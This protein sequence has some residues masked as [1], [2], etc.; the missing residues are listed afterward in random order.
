MDQFRPQV[1][2]G[3]HVLCWVLLKQLTSITEL[4]PEGP[5]RLGFFL[6]SS[7]D[8]SGYSFRKFV[9]SSYLEFRKID[10]FHKPSDSE[11]YASS[12]EH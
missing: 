9:F 3:S 1:W 8:G 7:E 6:P 11:C 4:L 5:N 2:G 10:K 12:S